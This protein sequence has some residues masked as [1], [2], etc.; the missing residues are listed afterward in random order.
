MGDS[1]AGLVLERHDGQTLLAGELEVGEGPV[2]SLLGDCG[3]HQR[4]V[5][6]EVPVVQ[7]RGGGHAAGA[8]PRAFLETTDL[9]FREASNIRRLAADDDTETAWLLEVSVL[10]QIAVSKT[11]ARHGRGAPAGNR[12]AGGVDRTSVAGIVYTLP[13]VLEQGQ[14]AD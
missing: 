14:S 3:F 8:L 1:G 13:P 7:D 12:I 6:A 11:C 10:L 9:P 2:H 5:L 4:F